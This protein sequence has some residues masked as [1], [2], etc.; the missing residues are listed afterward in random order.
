MNRSESTIKYNKALQGVLE[1]TNGYWPSSSSSP[2]STKRCIN[3][4]TYALTQKVE[5]I[6]YSIKIQINVIFYVRQLI[7]GA[8][9]EYILLIEQKM[10]QHI[11]VTW[12]IFILIAVR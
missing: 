4:Q 1:N 6:F 2:W 5:V 11:K 7:S 12:S 9:N 8:D 3:I 10:V